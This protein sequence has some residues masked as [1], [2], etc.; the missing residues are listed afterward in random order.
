MKVLLVHPSCLMYSEIYLR[1]EPLGLALVAQ[2]CREAGHDVR[3]L[4]LQVFKR[5]EY[6]KEVREW[7]PD[8]IGFSLNYM[9]NIPEVVDLVKE[10][11]KVLP[12]SFLFAGGHSA[13]FIPAEVLDHAGG[14][15]DCVIRG[16]GEA[17]T[18]RVLERVASGRAGLE[19]LPGVVTALGAGPDP[20]LIESLDRLFP[21]RDL[22]RRRRRY[23][24]ADLD[25]CASVELTRGCPWDCSFCS[26][27]TFYGRS[28]RK[29]SPEKAA[30]DLAGIR[31]PNVFIVDDVAFVHAE[32]GMAVARE[33]ERRRIRKR[34]YLE[35]RA[36]VLLRNKEVFRRWRKLGLEY[37]FVGLEAIDEEGLKLHRKRT[38]L[39]KNFEALEF[40]RSLGVFVAVNIIS[41]PSWDERRFEAIREWALSV[42]EIVHLT[43]NTPYPGTETW[44]TESRKLQTRDYR[45]F[46]VQHAVLPTKMPLEKF[47]AE[48]V[49]TQQVLN[50]KHLGLPALRDAF[51]IALSNLLRGQTNFLRMLWKFNT[52]YN[53]RRQ[54]SDHARPVQYSMRFCESDIPSKVN[55]DALYVHRPAAARTPVSSN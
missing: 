54:L 19:S 10:T 5:E 34:Y 20:Q 46:D 1:L 31:E 18:P 42:P 33:I 2:S 44:L 16:E 40:A 15:L 25:P 3:L 35:T 51:V 21:A 8:A 14:A 37:M 11:R 45:L 41:D 26:A 7:R 4:D 22:L 55:R 30:E 43:V 39:S 12:T 52:V 36:D 23:F 9:A 32:H 13:S 6:F 24:I 48:L 53:P 47:Y 28:Y 27:W 50:R 17:I 29:V 49:R 38:S